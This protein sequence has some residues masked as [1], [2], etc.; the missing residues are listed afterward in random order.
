M[1]TT[2]ENATTVVGDPGVP[3]KA[4][5]TVLS[6]PDL[7]VDLGV[8]SAQQVAQEREMALNEG[9]PLI[10]VLVRDGLVLSRE[11][12][13]LAALHLGL[14]MVDLGSQAI[15]RETLALVPEAVARKYLVL[16]LAQE[17]GSLDVAMSDPTDL[18]LLQDLTALSGMPVRPV[19]ATPED[20]LEHIDVFYRIVEAE[21]ADTPE[22]KGPAKEALS[23]LWR[24]SPSQIIDVMVKQALQDRASDIHIDPAE[25]RLRVRFRIDGL[26]H[27]VMSFP[28]DI[29][30]MLISRLKIMSGM[31][32][33]ERRRPQ[34]GQF[35]I[36]LENRAVDV[37]VAV[38]TTVTGEMAVLRLLDKQFTLRGLDQLGMGPTTLEQWR[39]LLRLPY[40]MAIV[41]GPTGA[42]KST[43]L[44]ASVLQMNRMERNIISI[45]D[46]VEYHIADINQMQVH[47][48]AGVTFAGQLRSILRL[49]PDV[50]LV[51]EIRDHE[52]AQIATQAA[53]TGHLVLTSLHANDAVSAIVRLQDLG[54]AP[55]LLASS[56]AGVLAQRMVRVICSGCR[57]TMARPVAEQ[58]AYAEEMGE[59][60]D[61]FAHGAGCNMCARTGY[62][63]RTGVFEALTISDELRSLLLSNAP[64]HALRQQA[65]EEGMVSLRR[66]GMRKVG[67]G[68]STPEEV[69]RVLFNMD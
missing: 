27:D 10:R 39:K 34:D 62:R 13:T 58:Q 20:I 54:V 45:E 47:A 63:G 15:A 19:I 22:N 48:E 4:R 1:E 60:K 14:S 31:N 7:L 36:K 49:D 26:L 33:A 67:E 16:P 42:G 32:I 37:R 6:L 61:R 53:L 24:Q 35:S 18:R 68:M 43:T 5:R 28:L 56:L 51:G 57:T 41:C 12:A 59:R 38:S 69:M 21:A 17:D 40:G 23:S 52:T 3:V 25:T 8:L 50:I 64:R 11:V 29:H 30:P 2:S 9:L 66:D 65:V 55:Y 46:P 44:Y